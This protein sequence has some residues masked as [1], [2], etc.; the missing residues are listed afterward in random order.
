M[1]FQSIL[2]AE[3]TDVGAKDEANNEAKGVGVLMPVKTPDI[4]V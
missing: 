1:R 4:P 2:Y 3:L